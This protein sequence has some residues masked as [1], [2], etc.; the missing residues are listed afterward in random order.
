MD[1][2]EMFSS[3]EAILFAAD[4]PVSVGRFIEVLTTEEGTGPTDSEIGEALG[5]IKSKFEAPDFGF[6]LRETHGGYQLTTK[7]KNVDVVRKFLAT[8][9]FR[10]GRSALETLSIVAYRQPITRAEIDVIRGIDSSH[11]LRTLIERGMVRMVGKAEIPG[12]PVVYG[13]TTKFLETVGLGSLNDLPPLAELD[14]LA[15]DTEDPI[16]AMENG[17]DKFMSTNTM[18]EEELDPS[19]GLEE[20]DNMLMTAGDSDG[21]IYA[22]A[23][24]REAGE[25]NRS[26]LACFQATI[27]RGRKAKATAETGQEPTMESTM[28]AAV[29]K[30]TEAAIQASESLGI[31][32]ITEIPESE[33]PIIPD[34]LMQVANEGNAENHPEQIEEPKIITIINDRDDGL[35]N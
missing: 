15:G 21:E 22:S 4:R 35:L 25:E 33:I 29:E 26:A 9:P 10:L 5:T 14:Q 1:S 20:I 23:V 13:T 34:E 8:K 31:E 28:Q 2:L 6:E 18:P 30:A 27:P 32:G 7:A 17:L 19:E 3:I 24:H 16:K 12:R 11:L